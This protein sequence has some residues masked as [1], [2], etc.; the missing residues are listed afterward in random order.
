MVDANLLWHTTARSHRG[1]PV[2]REVG[3]VGW[4]SAGNGGVFGRSHG[5][6]VVVIAGGYPRVVDPIAGGRVWGDVSGCLPHELQRV[7]RG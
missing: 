5:Q 2:E 3:I 1:S 4:V 6:G 7:V